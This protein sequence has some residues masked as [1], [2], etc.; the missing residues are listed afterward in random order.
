MDE[1]AEGSLYLT[2]AYL[3]A[4]NTEAANQ[5]RARYRAIV[6]RMKM[7]RVRGIGRP[8]KG[9]TEVTEDLNTEGTELTE[10]SISSFSSRHS[11][12][13]NSH[14]HASLDE[15]VVLLHDLQHGTE[16]APVRVYA[17][18]SFHRTT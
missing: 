2:D 5:Q 3:G 12:F 16:A 13:R 18:R 4:G 15:I 8:L 14:T 1:T 10:V 7:E 9:R 6:A 11:P 17:Q